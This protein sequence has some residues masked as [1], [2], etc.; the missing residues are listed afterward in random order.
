MIYIKKIK[1]P[2]LIIALIGIAL[3]IASI[4]MLLP[5][6]NESDPEAAL[7]GSSAPSS[8]TSSPD[9][10]STPDDT[11]K[12]NFN[13][14]VSAYGVSWGFA[15]SDP[16][17]N[18]YLYGTRVIE[19]FPEE[20]YILPD[21]VIVTGASYTWYR[22]TG[23]LEIYNAVSDVYVYVEGVINHTVTLS[24]QNCGITTG[25]KVVKQGSNVSFFPIKPKTD[26]VVTSDCIEIIGTYDG[27]SYNP[28]NGQLDIYGVY[29]DISVKIVAIE[30]PDIMRYQVTINAPDLSVYTADGIDDYSIKTGQHR[31]FEISP[32]SG[33]NLLPKSITVMG[34][35]YI[36]RPDQCTVEIFNARTDVTIIVDAVDLVHINITGVN[37]TIGSFDEV[38]PAGSTVQISI[39]PDGGYALRA[40]LMDVT[41]DY[42]ALKRLEYNVSSG[43]LI[44]HE[45]KSDIS[46]NV[47]PEPLYNSY[48]LTLNTYGSES[49]F[50][51]EK[52]QI[53]PGDTVQ[54][55][56]FY[57]SGR[58][59]DYYQMMTI[60]GVVEDG[61]SVV[62][63][64]G[65]NEFTIFEIYF[66]EDFADHV[67]PGT[68]EIYFN[69]S[70]IGGVQGS[71]ILDANC[72]AGGSPGGPTPYHLDPGEYSLISFTIDD[73]C[74]CIDGWQCDLNS[75]FWE[76][77]L[78]FINGKSYVLFH[79]LPECPDDVT[80]ITFT[81][82]CA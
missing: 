65:Y 29:S 38:V 9:D 77:E 35:D 55:I 50:D 43:I 54:F 74:T 5:A 22:S 19:I 82:W 20:G 10:P 36:Y 67:Y 52:F 31:V 68:E 42:G 12:N 28:V 24:A 39:K 1:K 72:N 11:V 3:I 49:T 60:E 48:T 56:A 23:T 16:T 37:C 71:V 57:G 27:Y 4:A 17:N 73:Y 70:T 34:A 2:I 15:D 62:N 61:W 21:S 7:P 69:T 64:I 6:D 33:V 80:F 44:L 53:V 14:S 51:V 75:D 26:Y 76:A 18:A 30:D 81:F 8:G 25:Y 41:C 79:L 40:E 59:L 63:Q 58:E 78:L 13:I 47:V 45:V 66:H 32:V 46:I